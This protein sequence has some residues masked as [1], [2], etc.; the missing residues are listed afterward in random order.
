VKRR[1]IP[2]LAGAVIGLGALLAVGLAFGAGLQ[3]ER[4]TVAREPSYTETEVLPV[5]TAS[6][7]A[8]PTDLNGGFACPLLG[9]TAAQA[10]AYFSEIGVK[11]QWKFESPIAADGSGHTSFRERV[12]MDSVVMEVSPT[13]ATTVVVGV[14]SAD[15]STPTHNTPSPKRDRDC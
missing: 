13:D 9:R 2:Q 4:T 8:G 6:T 15:D 5:T 10:V 7:V 14:H 3:R 11:I 1:G 12:P